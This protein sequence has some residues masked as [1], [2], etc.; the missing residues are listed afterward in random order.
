MGLFDNLKPAKLGN[1]ND[2]SVGRY[3]Q[4]IDK[5]GVETDRTQTNQRVQILKTNLHVLD[6]T[7]PVGEQVS[8]AVFRDPRYDYFEKDV[9]SFLKAAF[10]LKDE[11]VNDL[12]KAEN[13][14]KFLTAVK[15]TSTHAG[16][17]GSDHVLEPTEIRMLDDVQTLSGVLHNLPKLNDAVR[18]AVFESRVTSKP[19]PKDASKPYLTV[20]YLRSVPTDEIK[21]TLPESRQ[22]EFFPAGLT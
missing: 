13:V 14:K 7:K 12:R 16:M 11:E 20:R 1:R 3:W 22:K 8:H 9:K 21:R 5:I 19:N 17:D 18:G 4:R 10:G 6:G 2:D 15:V